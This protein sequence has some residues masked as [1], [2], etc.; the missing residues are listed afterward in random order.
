[1]ALYECKQLVVEILDSDLRDA[2]E[3]GKHRENPNPT[4]CAA[5]ESLPALFEWICIGIHAI[6]HQALPV[7]ADEG[8]AVGDEN[9][10][11]D[12]GNDCLRKIGGGFPGTD[13]VIINSELEA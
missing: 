6:L 5:A 13:L 2:W 12:V 4:F 8:A 9:F 1:M 10:R 11:L 3:V 7:L